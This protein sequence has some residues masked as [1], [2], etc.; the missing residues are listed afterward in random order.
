MTRD[1]L[2]GR[3]TVGRAAPGSPGRGRSHRRTAGWFALGLAGCCVTLTGLQLWLRRREENP[4]WRRLARAVPVVGH[5]L[6]IA[7]AGS[8]IGFFLSLPTAQTLFW[9][10]A[11]F[12]IAAALAIAAGRAVREDG[13]LARLYRIALGTAFV[14]WLGAV[15]VV[16]WLLAA[17]APASPAPSRSP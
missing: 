15:S 12:L 13:A 14:M 10:P 2:D 16:G 6:P 1:T 5:G 11:G 17:R 4:L 7:M 9:T 3:L 8:G